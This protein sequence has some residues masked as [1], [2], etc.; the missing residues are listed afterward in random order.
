MSAP[1]IAIIGAG[2]SGLAAGIYARLNGY[3]AVIFE[4]GTRPG[5]VSATWKRR[6]FTIDGG[7]HFY[8]G[9]LRPGPTREFFKEL[10]VFQEDKYRPI[11][12]YARFLDQAQGLSLD[13]TPDLDRF[14]EEAGE[15]S[16]QD[17]GFLR[18]FRAGARAFSKA[19]MVSAMAKPPEL[20][21]VWDYLR[22]MT[23]QWQSLR[24]YTGRYARPMTKA[25]KD[26]EHPWLREVFLNMFLPEV[27]Y[28][29]NLMLAGLLM[30][31]NLATRVDGSAG[32]NQALED[33][34]TS[35]GGEIRYRSRVE[36]VLIRDS[37]A[38]GLRLQDGRE[39]EADWVVSAA[40]GRS[41][42]F[43]LV[44]EEF[45]PPQLAKIYQDLDL[46]DPVAL[47][48]LGVDRE[49]T[50]HPENL[51]LRP[52]NQPSA[53]FPSRE[54]WFVRVFDSERGFTRRASPWS[55]S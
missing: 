1:K 37:R 4:H 30:S 9:C 17:A 40:D 53:G 10:G 46:F 19:D 20:I 31:K 41:T 43:D 45:V 48:H 6:G 36:K 28:F 55:R 15:I 3:E 2:L 52:V 13:L 29:F 49:L 34:F 54:W 25:V 8:M 22:M 23:S 44:G 16:P 7:I 50:G 39:E 27:P 47:V 5:G 42:L 14:V 51:V 32:F 38:V 35:L 11:Q 33:H 12:T 21:T 18:S 24:F 26:L